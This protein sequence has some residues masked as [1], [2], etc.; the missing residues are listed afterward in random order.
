M[1]HRIRVAVLRGG[2]DAEREV[3]L[4]SGA[5]V[6]AALDQEPRFATTDHVIDRPDAQELAAIEADVFFPVLHGPFGEGGVLQE[7]LETTGRPYVGCDP[8]ASRLAMDKIA[9]K[10]RCTAAG[11]PT[12]AWSRLV[13][14]ED[15]ALEPPVVLKPVSEGS[16][17]GVRICR[18]ST[19]LAEARPMLEAD[20]DDIMIERFV[21]GRELTVG[22]ALG[23]VLPTI[24]IVPGDGFYDYEAKYERDDTEYIVAP[25]LP[26][27]VDETCRRHAMATFEALGCRDLARVDFM[28]DDEGPWLLE[29]NTIPGFTDHSLVPMAAAK[30]GIGMRELC[31][32][33]VDVA[34]ERTGTGTPRN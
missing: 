29:V 21:A 30:L 33:L 15:P 31:T 5:R 13:P 22:V 24:E 10:E 23:R 34:L 32:R 12:A 16:S 6:L 28:L 25:P 17:V 18:T 14:G 3:S 19:E 2:P 11:I 9:T 7:R 8:G 4:D 27:G 20:H 26:D 1:T